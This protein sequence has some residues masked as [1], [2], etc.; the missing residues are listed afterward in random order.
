MSISTDDNRYTKC[1]SCAGVDM[2]IYRISFFFFCLFF[3]FFFLIF[4]SS[5]DIKC[6]LPPTGKF[7]CHQIAFIE[8]HD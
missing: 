7:L 8:N 3:F 4:F 5:S 2:L 1:A 6:L